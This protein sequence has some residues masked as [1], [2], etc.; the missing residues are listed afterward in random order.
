MGANSFLLELTPFQKGNEGQKRKQEVAE[1]ISDV[2]MS[3]HLPCEACPFKEGFML[4][5]LFI[6]EQSI[7][8]PKFPYG[9]C[10]PG[11]HWPRKSTAR[12]YE[13]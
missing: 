11:Y 3:E 2:K 6:I 7:Y 9:F 5:R 12:L 1:V 10:S 8:T 13:I 4:G